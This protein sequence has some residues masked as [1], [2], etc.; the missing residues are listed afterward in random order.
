[1]KLNLINNLNYMYECVVRVYF[2]F[3]RCN[4]LVIIVSVIDSYWPRKIAFR[5]LKYV[6]IINKYIII[7]V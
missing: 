4:L 5:V 6:K 2:F 1:M 7:Y 3:V